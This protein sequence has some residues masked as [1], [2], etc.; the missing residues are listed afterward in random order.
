M[1]GSVGAAAGFFGVEGGVVDVVAVP[2]KLGGA[3]GVVGPVVL[4]APPSVGG[5][6]DVDVDVVVVGVVVAGSA[7]VFGC[8]PPQATVI[9]PIV[10]AT[11][12]PTTAP[13]ALSFR[14]CEFTSSPLP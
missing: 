10:T 13:S 9:A 5:A 8:W 11:P 7:V 12:A 14:C 4:P 6:V 1:A 3:D 2:A